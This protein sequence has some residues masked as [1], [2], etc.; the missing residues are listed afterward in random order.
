MREIIL[1][2]LVLSF[3]G[4]IQIFDEP[5]ILLERGPLGGT[6]YAGLVLARYLHH[7]AFNRWHFGYGSAIAY[8]I[9]AL[10]ALLSLVN[11]KVLGGRRR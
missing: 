8:F 10:I 5:F 2:S 9:V 11:I 6:N 7:E 4:G 1:F 3:I